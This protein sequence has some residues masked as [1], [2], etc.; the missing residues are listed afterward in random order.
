MADNLTTV[1]FR[2]VSY[3]SIASSD[4]YEGNAVNAKQ[5]DQV[6]N[7]GK[8]FVLHG[9]ANTRLGEGVDSKRRGQ[10]RHKKGICPSSDHHFG[11]HTALESAVQLNSISYCEPTFQCDDRQSEDRKH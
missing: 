6:D 9:Q 1:Q 7:I 3:L 11:S 4:E 2:L 8:G 5:E 10:Q